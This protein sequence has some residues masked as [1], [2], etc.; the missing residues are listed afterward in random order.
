MEKL[1]KDHAQDASSEN[2]KMKV[3]TG[4]EDV[5]VGN[6]MGMSSEGWRNTSEVAINSS[7]KRK[8]NNRNEVAKEEDVTSKRRQRVMST[9]LR[10]IGE[11]PKNS[12]K[13]PQKDSGSRR[14]KNVGKGTAEV[15][16]LGVISENKKRMINV[17]SKGIE[18]GGA[19]G[20]SHKVQVN[21][22]KDPR[23]SGLKRKPNVRDGV[24]ETKVT[25]KK[26][27]SV[28]TKHRE[29]GDEQKNSSEE[30]QKNYGSRRKHNIGNGIAKSG[31][32]DTNKGKEQSLMCHQCQR[33]DKGAVVFCLK[34]NRKRYCYPCL[35]KWY[36]EQTKEDIEAG[37][38]FCCGNCN[39]KACLRN[40]VLMDNT[41]EQDAKVKLQRLLYLLHKVLPL[42]RQIHF[43]H[44]LE[45]EME[46]K[47]QGIQPSEVNVIRCKL[48]KE[49]R[50]YCDNCNTS[51]VDFHRSCSNCSYDLCL[52]CCC[53]LRK[54]Q[55]PGGIE[56]NS[57]HQQF[58]GRT[59]NQVMDAREET[60][61]RIASLPIT[62]PDWRANDDGSIPCPP[63]ER[64]GCGTG[65]L[66]LQRSFKANWVAKL[67]RNAED[68][69]NL[70]QF[71]D[72][73]FCHH[74]LSCSPNGSSGIEGGSS[75]VRR[76]AF[77]DNGS[78]N[79]LYCPNALDFRDDDIGHFQKHWVRGEPVIVRD[80]LKRTSGLSWEPMVM[81]RAL[82]EKSGK[83]FKEA[84]Q[85][86]K[87]INCLDWCEV[88][89]N[90]HQFFQGYVEG[91]MHKNLWPEMLKL[92]DWPPS[93]S[94]EERLPRH[95]AEFISSL[96]YHDYTHPKSGLLNLAAKLPDSVLKPDLGPKAY[97]AYGSCEELGRGDSVTKLHCDMSDA[98][99]ILTHTAEVKIAK[100]QQDKIRKI[101]KKFAEEDMR[102]LYG[103]ADNASSKLT[104]SKRSRDEQLNSVESAPT[105][106]GD[107]FTSHSPS[108]EERNKETEQPDIRK[109]APIKPATEWPVELVL[110]EPLCGDVSEGNSH[111][112]E[113]SVIKVE[114]Q[115]KQRDVKEIS[116]TSKDVHRTDSSPENL[117]LRTKPLKEE[118]L[119][120]FDDG[121]EG[122]SL[123]GRKSPRQEDKDPSVEKPD[124]QQVMDSELNERMTGNMNG[125][126]DSVVQEQLQ[127]EESRSSKHEDIT[128]RISSS[129]DKVDSSS[130]G[131]N[132]Y[133]SDE[134]DAESN[135]ISCGNSCNPEDVS[136]DDV[137]LKRKP[138]NMNEALGS[139]SRDGGLTVLDSKKS[140]AANNSVRSDD[141]L[142]DVYGGAVW[143]IF[144]REDV[145]KIIEY[146]QKHSKEFR[147]IN[148][149]PVNS[150]THPIHDQTLYLNEKHKK[151]LKEEFDVEPWTFEQHL[152]EAV[153][154]PAGCPHQVRNRQSCIKV[155]LDFVSP[156][157]VQECIRLTEEFRLLPKDHRAKEDKLE[158]KKM[159][160][161]AVSAAIREANN[162]VLQLNDKEGE[163]K[164][165]KNQDG[166]KKKMKR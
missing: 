67:I 115:D 154:I 30:L 57:S 44:N 131:V 166:E 93:T 90:I 103:G 2:E 89:I 79:F 142:K 40:V 53:E 133:C 127:I 3:L 88:E 129:P 74:C 54:G 55:Q 69:I 145:P 13:E 72:D 8:L 141:T 96:P 26:Q 160:V 36:P 24:T 58:K 99:N 51:I 33:N 135:A 150:V 41:Q 136:S 164:E 73:D 1:K 83:K 12:C 109:K 62:F 126:T 137:T 140:D 7:H 120:V 16:V 35:S 130:N 19:I 128:R 85:K 25:G 144:R 162:L 107:T 105:K 165:L 110:K 68:L 81:W 10:E 77:R 4:S 59:C 143:D 5:E 21:S 9:K 75:E 104:K 43:E 49:E 149:L 64:G 32:L 45:I 34:C 29:F 151:Q 108:L 106:C 46:A 11:G 158:V 125:E 52:T 23:K 138:A 15:R 111:L 17:G 65:L 116:S 146:L 92:K 84:I 156:E 37:C 102:E 152:G 14:K 42:L 70:F 100:W 112:Q 163:K 157:N 82:R 61:D 91:R 20:D 94:F 86:V 123:S 113:E 118:H 60:S 6:G 47:I 31:G 134:V 147:H 97:I 28:G 56:A 22:C 153:F 63:E 117:V 121:T 132:G 159:A 38:P 76:T 155:A 66:A 114:L 78:D 48:D 87:A 148:S 50:R 161:Y 124:K 80:V 95:W 122:C 39:C 71:S 27:S 18:F 139:F 98:V 101:H 119:E